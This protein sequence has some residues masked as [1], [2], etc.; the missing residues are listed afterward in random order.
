MYYDPVNGYWGMIQDWGPRNEVCWNLPGYGYFWIHVEVRG[1]DGGIEQSTIGYIA[2]KFYVNVKDM[3]VYTPDSSTYF[4]RQDVETNDPNIQYRYLIYD[5][6]SGFWQE[7]PSG[8]TTFWQPSISGN[9]LIHAIIKDSLGNEHTNTIGYVVEF[10]EFDAHAKTVMHNIIYAVETGGQ[11]YGRAAYDTFCP[12][13]NISQKET[14]ITIGA[15]GWFATEAQKLLKLIRE[16][17][18]VMFAS[19]DDADISY[20][21]DNC[22]WSYYGSDGEGN[23]T[24]DRNSEKALCIQKI[25]S[26]NIGM[27]VQDELLDAEMTIYVNEAQNLGVNDL[28]A[29][30]FCANI[31]HLGGYSAMRSVIE[32]CKADGL[33]L[34]MDNLWISMRNHT[35]NLSGNGVGANKYKTRHEK[36]MLWLDTYL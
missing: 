23:R 35:S 9:Y 31:R 6:R 11:I 3:V 18:P 4:I 29:R 19:L 22:N 12:A 20:D 32:N 10:R 17:D 2:E 13:F 16:R 8:E 27:Q 25:I 15:G 1:T 5:I 33:A 26:T 28:K 14:A 34:T 21:L 36:V 24:I 7:L 30:M